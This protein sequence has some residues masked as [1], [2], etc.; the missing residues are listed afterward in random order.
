[1]VK[2]LGSCLETKIPLLVYEFIPNEN[3]FEYLQQK[4]EDF[5]MTCDM[6]LRIDT[7]VVGVLLYY[8]LLLLNLFIIKMTS[9]QIYN[10][11]KSIGQN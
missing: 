11:M 3:L 1:M 5:P 2:L 10:W 6:R 8:T 7:E 4:N 9:Q